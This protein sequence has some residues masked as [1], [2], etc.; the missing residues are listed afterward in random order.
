MSKN[1][2]SEVAKLLGL[3]LSEEFKIQGLSL[4]Y[5]LTNIGLQYYNETEGGWLTSNKLLPMLL[6]GELSIIKVEQPILDD[7]ETK[8]LSNIIK[9]FRNKVIGITKYGYSTNGEYIH[10]KLKRT[11]SPVDYFVPLECIDLPVFKRGIMYKGMKLRRE[12]SLKE[13]EL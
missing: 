12:Y 9:P 11:I 4:R 1:K 2:M 7:I 6:Q 8:Y 5:R 13:L 10:I 3:E